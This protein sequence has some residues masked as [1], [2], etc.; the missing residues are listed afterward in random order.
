MPLDS[1]L[2]TV[3]GPNGAVWQGNALDATGCAWVVTAEDGWS[4]SPPARPSQVDK[5]VGDGTW[6]GMG[7]FAGRLV[8][9]TGTCIAPSQLAMLWAKE[10]IKAAIDPHNLATLRVDELH[11]S[12]TAQVRLS[13]KVEIQDQGNVAFTFTMGL[14]A[15]DPRRYAVS[16]VSLA[17][18]LPAGATVGRAYN[19]TYPVSY[20]GAGLTAQGSVTF[21]NAGSYPQ[22]P[23]VITFYGPVI[24]P[25]VIHA[26]SG[27][28]LTFQLTLNYGQTLVVDLGAQSAL[29]A[30]TS[31][32]IQALTGSSAWF[33]LVPGQNQLLFRGQAGTPP[34]GITAAPSML[35]VAS[36]AWS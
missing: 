11:L 3:T 22:S 9:L 2:Y 36:S 10:A 27:K 1:P 8:T 7:Y 26:Q 29:A 28:S 19:R 25:E 15:P 13:D 35:V 33:M 6:A 17:T 31:S 16:S 12:R 21:W 5:T 18:G 34:P 4:S 32:V 30:G 14:F 23:G 24:N 20:G